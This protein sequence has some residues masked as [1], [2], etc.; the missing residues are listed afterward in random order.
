MSLQGEH[1]GL[2]RLQAIS[3][4]SFPHP[5]CDTKPRVSRN[6]KAR[7]TVAPEE[8]GSGRTEIRSAESEA[9]AAS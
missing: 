6:S 5:D 3:I 9:G 4:L 2:A 7:L 8:N 1:I